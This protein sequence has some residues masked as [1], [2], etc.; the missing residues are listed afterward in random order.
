MKKI[1]PLV[2]VGGILLTLIGIGISLWGF[3]TPNHEFFFYGI[4]P[5]AIGIFLAGMASV[6]FGTLKRGK[7]GRF[8]DIRKGKYF[9]FLKYD[10]EKEGNNS[11]SNRRIL[12][13]IRFIET[14]EEC[15]VLLHTFDFE[16]SIKIINTLD[17]N[18]RYYKKGGEIC[19]GSVLS[20]NEHGSV[21]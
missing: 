11:N 8:S 14:D 21:C 20:P 12:A 1:N 2:L 19:A 9:Q 18:C 13:R 7:R 17:T 16:R 4:I 15:R 10:I 3:F 6:G 5:A